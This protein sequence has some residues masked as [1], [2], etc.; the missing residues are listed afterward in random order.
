LL[1][2]EIS[3]TV[4]HMKTIKN[5]EKKVFSY[6]EKHHMLE[7]GDRVIAGIS[8]GADSVCLLFVLL[9]W[10]KR[11][12]L[13]L[14]VVH[15]NHGIRQDAAEDAAYV[16]KLCRENG[17]KCYLYHVDVPAL[18]AAEKCSLEEAGRKARYR[19]FES[20]AAD[21]TTAGEAAH[22]QNG[23]ACKIA[24]AHNANDCSETMLFHLFRGSGLRGLGSIRPV[25][26]NIIR[27][28]LCL[29]RSEIEEYL[30]CRKIAYCTDNTNASDDY[31]RN[32]IRHHILPFAEEHIVK[33][34][35]SHMART[36]E[37]LA[38]TEDYLEEQTKA[39]L[40]ACLRQPDV[41]G[42]Q[43][44]ETAHCDITVQQSWT[45]QSTL[46][47]LRVQNRPTSYTLCISTLLSQHSLMQKRILHQV[48]KNLSPAQKDIS[49]GHIADLLDLFTGEGN[50][51]VDLPFGIRGRREYDRV[52]VDIVNETGRDR[53][54][55]RPEN[56]QLQPEG[57]FLFTELSMEHF[58][59]EFQKKPWEVSQN[60]C[61]KWLDYDKIKQSL[62]S[63]TRKK[64]DYFTIADSSG[65]MVRK[66]LKDYMIDRKIPRAE[67]DRLPLLAEGS[68]VVWL[69]GHRISEYYKITADTKHILQVQYVPKTG[70]ET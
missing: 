50:R 6:I 70:R 68:H 28:I 23:P 8:G 2:C 59:E 64:G 30:R 40:E 31:T 32:R 38:E 20:A 45:E 19:A 44:A 24:V 36:A 39:A 7:A 42:Q 25:R 57:E 53:G 63:R 3:S 60:E 69:V 61:T 56:T 5:I 65:K 43:L 10:A 15:V 62:D 34:S 12:S 41:S 46:N 55:S 58:T 51:S 13:E 37:L 11:K 18:A 35:I 52:I 67:R 22:V 66:S 27:P 1:N 9:E 14:E 33:G 4:K 21:F 29:D 26:D 16:E 49:Y 54:S 47:E 17:L 48:V